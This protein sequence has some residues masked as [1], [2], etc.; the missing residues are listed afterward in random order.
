MSAL[1]GFNLRVALYEGPGSASLNDQ[2]RFELLSALLEAGYDVTRA[3]CGCGLPSV[4]SSALLI[5]GRFDNGRPPAVGGTGDT[6]RVRSQDI[7]GLGAADVVALAGR[8][9]DEIGARKPGAW[10]PWFPAIDYERCTN[11]K[12]C[13]SFCLFGV[14]GLDDD[15]RIRVQNPA[16]CKTDCPACARVCP[17]VAIIFAKHA[18]GPINGDVVREEDLRRRPVQVDLSTL[19]GGDVRSALRT[20]RT[21]T[22]KRFST[23]RDEAPTEAECACRREMIQAELGI[24]DQVWAG[25]CGTDETAVSA[26]CQEES[27]T[28]EERDSPSPEEWGI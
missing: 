2:E 13:L 22:R 25:L 20:R 5:L 9:G 23:E 14:F 24:P 3:F 10:K 1:G 11:C 26:E 15:D 16:N 28:T 12:Q 17:T 8:I 21:G 27:R 6:A 7:S 19:V 18:A 4:D